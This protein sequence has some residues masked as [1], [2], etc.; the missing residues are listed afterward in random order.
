MSTYTAAEDIAAG[1]LVTINNEGQVVLAQLGDNVAGMAVPV[2]HAPDAVND[3]LLVP[4]FEIA[5][6]PQIRL[7]EIRERRFYTVEAAEMMA[8]EIDNEFINA[9]AASIAA[10][11]PLPPKPPRPSRWDLVT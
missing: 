1:A 11:R 6:N 2:E 10:E 9:V 5:S 4:T 7:S 3:N 8:A